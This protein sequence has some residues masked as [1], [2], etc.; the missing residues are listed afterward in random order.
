MKKIMTLLCTLAVALPALTVTAAAESAK[1]L[2][3]DK[4]SVCH[5]LSDA[6]SMRMD[7]A[8]WTETVLRMKNSNGA[9]VTDEE[10]RRII[11]YLT[12]NYGK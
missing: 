11:D 6:T 3:A 2:F 5:G 7:K 12:E 4:C 10:A 8:G 1:A 9:Y